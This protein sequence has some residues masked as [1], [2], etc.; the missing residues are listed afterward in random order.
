MNF[1]KSYGYVTCAHALW[2]SADLK[3]AHYL[4]IAPRFTFWAQMVP[5]LVSTF[6]SI[7]VLQY[8]LNIPDVCTPEA[9]FRFT[10]PGNNTFF[11]ASVFWGT[12]GP[13]KIWGVGGQ[14]AVTLI[15]F[16][17]GVVLVA[18]FYLLGRKWPK[19]PIIRNAHPVVMMYGAL[20]WAPL[21]LAY[22]WPAV[23]VAA[24]SWLYLKKRY[25]AFW[26]KVCHVPACCCVPSSA[27][28]ELT[29]DDSTTS[30]L[31]PPFHAVS[32]SAASS[33]SLP[34]RSSA[35]S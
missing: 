32:R 14:Y 34:S 8:Q 31:R 10:C 16:P 1:F 4:K 19:N 12:I 11:T 28:R 22:L 30:S 2:F 27:R 18:A 7:A 6:I 13:R 26:S 29:S 17:L 25:L 20:S 9:P 35:L 24:F 23:P 15:G 3:L 33:S 5:T 21:N